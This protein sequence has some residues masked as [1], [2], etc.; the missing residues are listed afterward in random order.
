MLNF[1]NSCRNVGCFARSSSTRSQSNKAWVSESFRSIEELK[2]FMSKETWSVNEYLAEADKKDLKSSVSEETAVKLLKLAGLPSEI[3]DVKRVQEKLGHQLA[4]INKLHEIPMSDNEIDEKH[5]RLLPR[6]KKPMTFSELTAAI[7]GDK[8]NSELG[9][10]S[11][12]W[13]PCKLAKLSKNNMFIVR[14][15]LMKNRN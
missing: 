13:T 4:F 15:G 10:I 7:K 14:K 8:Q 5:S 11:E 6:F 3:N 2:K 1:G 9:E 12:S